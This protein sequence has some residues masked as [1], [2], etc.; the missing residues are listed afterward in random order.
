[1]KPLAG[2]L[3]PSEWAIRGEITKA[4]L[5]AFEQALIG[6][7]LMCAFAGIDPGTGFETVPPED[8]SYSDHG[9]IARE[10]LECNEEGIPPHTPVLF[11]RWIKT[12]GE[13]RARELVVYASELQ[14]PWGGYATRTSPNWFYARWIRR[15]AHLR[16]IESKRAQLTV[17]P[18]EQIA[19]VNLELEVLLNS[20][21]APPPSRKDS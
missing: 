7:F 11:E 16:R 8:Y 2:P 18:F 14:S 3:N 12:F 13:N 20:I 17:A 15:A 1:M 19:K 9:T 10:I 6:N 5:F 21:P 4:G